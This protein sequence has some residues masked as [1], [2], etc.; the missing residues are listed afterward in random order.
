MAFLFSINFFP[1]T[2]IY[3]IAAFFQAGI[4]IISLNGTTLPPGTMLVLSVCVCASGLTPGVNYQFFVT[5]KNGVSSVASTPLV[6]VSTT[7]SGSGS[8]IGAVVGTLAAVILLILIGAIITV[9]M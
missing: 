6:F 8:V 4:I 5:A 2:C 7:G 9:L 1:F 3:S